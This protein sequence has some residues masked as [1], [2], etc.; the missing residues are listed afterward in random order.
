M[1]YHDE[2]GRKTAQLGTVMI[3]AVAWAREGNPEKPVQLLQVKHAPV[4][5][6]RVKK[7]GS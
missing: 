5:E 6:V 2:M 3:S 7:G 1:T 4:G